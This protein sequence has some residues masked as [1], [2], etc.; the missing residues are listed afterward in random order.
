MLRGKSRIAMLA[1]SGVIAALMVGSIVVASNMGFKARFTLTGGVSNWF[2]PPY[3]SP[4]ASAD[5]L[6]N[7]VAPSGGIVNRFI[8]S[9]PPAV[10]FWTGGAGNGLPQ[11]FALKPGEG[12]DIQPNVNEDVIVVGAHDPFVTVPAGQDGLPSLG[13]NPAG[14][15]IPPGFIGNRDYLISVPYHTTYQ[16]VDDMLKDLPG[17]GTIFRLDQ[18]PGNPPAFFFWTGSSGND[19]P[20]NFAME[21]GRAYQVRLLAASAGFTPAHF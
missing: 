8:P 9:S 2:S 12:Y 4:Y 14:G 3:T 6:L 18:A 10:Q 5:D 11:N 20:Q 1:A 17:G 15:S 19:T 13:G 21:L 16:V 7:A